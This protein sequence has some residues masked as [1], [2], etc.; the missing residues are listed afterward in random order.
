V[1]VA[2]TVRSLPEVRA[3]QAP[4]IQKVAADQPAA[5]P[6]ASP[7]KCAR[8][9]YE[10]SYAAAKIKAAL[11]D[12][13]KPN[14]LDFTETPLQQ[15]VAALQDEYGIPMQLDIAALQDAGINPQEPITAN[16]HSISLRSALRI[17]LGQHQLT[18]IIF[19]ETLIIT[20]PEQ[21]QT[22][23]VVSVYDVR[24]LL[25]SADDK[26]A[27]AALS[28]AIIACVAPETWA[29]NGGGQAAIRPL[30]PGFLVISQTQA[31]HEGIH[32]LMDQLRQARQ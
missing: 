14:G 30:K 9:G 28:D 13:L 3:D 4:A 5:S 19:N 27:M 25:T 31:V 32:D 24:D 11:A 20:T 16:L 6:V 18:Y 22:Q 2:L 29:N 15:V 26:D 7:A 8:A 23:L 1:V 21:A 12:P 10:A 17:L